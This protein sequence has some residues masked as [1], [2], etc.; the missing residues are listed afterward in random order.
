MNDELTSRL[1][2]QLHDQVDG[3]HDT[4]LTLEGVQGRARM[5][6][7]SM[8]AGVRCGQQCGRLGR[9]TRPA[10]PSSPKRRSHL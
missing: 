1:S 8:W 10:G 2:R 6:R 4:P 5:I 7:R 3:W 9:S